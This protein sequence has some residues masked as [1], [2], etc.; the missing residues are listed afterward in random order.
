MDD[1]HLLMLDLDE[2][3]FQVPPHHGGQPAGFW[4]APVGSCFMS[5]G[6]A[7]VWRQFATLRRQLART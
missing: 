2:V 4:P 3:R 1:G 6:G 7:A 5:A